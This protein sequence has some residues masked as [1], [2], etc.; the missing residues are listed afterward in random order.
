M[1]SSASGSSISRATTT[2]ELMM[3]GGP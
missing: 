2:P 1:F 3:M